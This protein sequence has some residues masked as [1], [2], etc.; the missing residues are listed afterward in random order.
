MP[1]ILKSVDIE[2]V[3]PDGRVIKGV[4]EYYPEH[5]KQILMQ[6]WD[7]NKKDSWLV[8]LHLAE[9]VKLIPTFEER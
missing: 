1:K 6:V 7:Y 3:Y 8:N 5:N 2:V 9:S 4:A